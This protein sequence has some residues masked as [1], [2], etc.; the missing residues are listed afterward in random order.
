MPDRVTAELALDHFWDALVDDASANVDGLD[1]LDTTSLRRLHEMASTPVPVRSS[2]RVQRTIRD[3]IAARANGQDLSSDQPSSLERIGARSAT[4]VDQPAS[5]P[6]PI[7]KLPA[8]RGARRWASILATAALLLLTLGASIQILDLNPLKR[9]DRGPAI[10]APTAQPGVSEQTLLDVVLTPEESGYDGQFGSGLAYHAVPP[11][12]HDVWPTSNGQATEARAF[13]IVNGT[14][15]VKG[16]H[17]LRV[18]RANTDGAIEQVPAD[19]WFTLNPGDAFLR[20]PDTNLELENPG[21]ESSY[22]LNWTL[23]GRLGNDGYAGYQPPDW[24]HIN[25]TWGYDGTRP[26]PPARFTLRHVTLEKGATLSAPNGAYFQFYLNPARDSRAMLA[27]D[28]DYSITNRGAASA[29]LF[30]FAM[31]PAHPDGGGTPSST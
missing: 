25:A 8:T 14:L 4:A 30:V 18:V 22:V 12:S 20:T 21:S 3:E 26:D 19:T 16:D 9:D 31:E 10:P 5:P 1:P 28:S 7:A 29:D 11:G 24:Q 23:G 13:Y 27:V 6:R 15:R 17:P 2:A